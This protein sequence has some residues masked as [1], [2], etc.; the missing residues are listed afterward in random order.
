[1]IAFTFMPSH[2]QNGWSPKHEINFN[3][4]VDHDFSNEGNLISGHIEYAYHFNDRLSVGIGTGAFL[5][6][7]FNSAFVPFSLRGEYD[8]HSGSTTPYVSLMVAKSL[9]ISDVGVGMA[10]GSSFV[11]PSIGIKVPFSR[12]IAAN[13]SI[14]YMRG[15]DENSGNLLGCNLGLSFGFGGKR[16]RSLTA[17]ENANE[18]NERKDE[19]PKKMSWGIEAEMYTSTEG[20]FRIKEKSIFG[21]RATAMWQLPVTGLRAGATVGIGF[22]N[23]QQTHYNNDGYWDESYKKFMFEILPRVRYTPNALTIA[24]RVSPF[25]QA[26]LGIARYGGGDMQFA[27]I[28]SIGL[29]VKTFESQSMQLSAGYLPKVSYDMGNKSAKGC[30]RIALGYEF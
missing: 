26:D 23:M 25:V 19:S 10:S 27:V 16:K 17:S 28:P 15:F 18:S 9:V 14:D 29:A 1:M 3:L 5:P 20:D 8:F 4:G 21:L 12:N 24:G 13:F 7:D 11:R 2:A 22:S 30:F 6:D